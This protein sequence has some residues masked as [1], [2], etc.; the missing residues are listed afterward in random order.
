[1]Y[2]H[3]VYSP[4]CVAVLSGGKLARKLF[5][6]ATKLMVTIHHEL[7]G[8]C[9]SPPFAFIPYHFHTGISFGLGKRLTR[10]FFDKY[11]CEKSNFLWCGHANFVY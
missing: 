3:L 10:V 7:V 11:G 9:T 4:E 2:F 8:K 6:Q 1:M 5:R